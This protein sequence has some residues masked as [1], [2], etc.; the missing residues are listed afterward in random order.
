MAAGHSSWLRT[1]AG[2]AWQLAA[3][4]ALQLAVHNIG[5]A[6][7]RLHTAAAA[8]DSGGNG[9]GASQRIAA[10][11]GSWA[12]TLHVAYEYESFLPLPRSHNPD[13]WAVGQLSS[14]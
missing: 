14:T 2:C 13:L 7:Q 10:G 6:Q 1:G 5:C 11:Y 9:G 12:Q 8:D 4:Y 3:G